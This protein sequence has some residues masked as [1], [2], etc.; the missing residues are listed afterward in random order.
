MKFIKK[1]TKD[2][3]FM[4]V[5]IIILLISLICIMAPQISPYDPFFQNYNKIL[6]AP[7]L[8]NLLGTDYVGRD[9]LSRILYGGRSSLF[10]ALTITFLVTVIG[11]I[12]G[13]FAGYNE[14]VLDSIIMRL[15]DI[16]MS[17][18][19]IVFVIALVSIFGASFKNLIL[20]MT[21]VSWTKYT[22]VSRSKVI[23]LKN[24][25][26]VKQ[27]RLGGANNFQIIFYYLLPNMFSYLL[28]M[29]SQD[30]ANNLLTLPV[31]SILGVGLP[32]PTP[33]WGYMIM[34]GK[35]YMQTAPWL[36]IFPGM[37][38]LLCVITFNL[39]GDIL[40]DILDPKN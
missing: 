23:E 16:V 32:P 40:R 27:A 34:E 4:I 11:T 8:E 26:F 10:I 15:T 38:I 19:Y 5:F 3:K 18:P 35:R 12:I 22:R 21:A 37:A 7:N 14:G 36:I 33:E 13:M 29:S 2:Y 9:I 28:V 1:I 17:F 25:D 30:I 6:Q 31:L 39:F 24:E 20:A